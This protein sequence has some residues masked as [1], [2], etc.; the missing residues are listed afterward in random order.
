ML[1]NVTVLTAQTLQYGIFLKEI[2][3]A[4]KHLLFRI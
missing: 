3:A 2:T 4:K 1:A